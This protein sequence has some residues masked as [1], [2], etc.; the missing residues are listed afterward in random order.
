MSSRA[1]SAQSII[2]TICA[3]VVTMAVVHQWWSGRERSPTLTRVP[4]WETLVAGSNRIGIEDAPLQLVEFVDFQCPFCEDLHWDLKRLLGEYP[5]ETSLTV[6]HAPIARHAA[7]HN[8]ARAAECAAPAGM[9]PEMVDALFRGQ[10]SLGLRPWSSYALEAGIRDTTRL[11]QCMD[12]PEI[13]EEIQRQ[14]AVATELGVEFTPTLMINGWFFPYQPPVD[15]LI[16]MAQRVA[17]GQT[18]FTPPNDW[19]FWGGP[20]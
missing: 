7:A 19:R 14:R 4:A 9:F 6:Y 15:S 3:V 8:A 11:L 20:R 1:E 18:P 5:S 2:V 10:D 17:A 12:D 16:D 13:S